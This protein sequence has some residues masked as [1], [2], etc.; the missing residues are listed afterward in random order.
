MPIRPPLVLEDLPVYGDEVVFDHGPI[1]E[2]GPTPPDTPVAVIDHLL[3]NVKAHHFST[4]KRKPEHPK[5]PHRSVIVGHLDLFSHRKFRT[6]IACADAKRAILCTAYR[7]YPLFY[8]VKRVTNDE[9]H[10]TDGSVLNLHIIEDRIIKKEG[11]RAFVRILEE[12][13]NYLLERQSAP[14]TFSFDGGL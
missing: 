8:P 13:K 5:P 14:D 7:L 9:L 6:Q 2:P 4:Q 3:Q 1:V 12:S 10:L 11:Y